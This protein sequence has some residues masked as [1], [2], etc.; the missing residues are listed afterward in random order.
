MSAAATPAIGSPPPARTGGVPKHNNFDFLRLFLAALVVFSHSWALGLGSE[1][2]E[3][4]FQLTRHTIFGHGTTLGHL[5]VNGFFVISG[6]LITASWERRRSTLDYFKKRAARIYPGFIVCTVL[7]VFALPYLVMPNDAW[8]HAPPV[9]FAL[10]TLRLHYESYPQDADGKSIAF[11]GNAYPGSTNGSLWSIPYEFWCYVGVAVLGVFGLMSRRASVLVIYVLSLLV[12]AVFSGWHIRFGGNVFGAV[13]GFPP[14]WARLLPFYLAGVVAWRYR[15]VLPFNAL[16][17]AIALI[18]LALTC[19][20][21]HG[22]SIGLPVFGAY[23]LLWICLEPKFP[24][25]KTSRWGDWSY[26]LYLYAFPVQQIVVWQFGGSMDP[27]LLCAIS[28]PVSLV[29]GAISWHVVEKWFLRAAHSVPNRAA[30]PSSDAVA[31][32][33]VPCSIQSDG[34]ESR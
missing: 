32:L 12:A 7:C 29:A 13:F 23:L 1:D 3:P 27:W 2:H 10:D 5:A 20:I 4:F 24:V 33:P 31:C 18:G 21:P 17:G 8:R 26:G 30:V 11:L 19:A 34:T 16:G 25:L 22:W 9:W 28:L 15:D 14:F 6:Y